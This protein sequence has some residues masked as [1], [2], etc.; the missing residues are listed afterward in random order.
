MTTELD[1]LVSIIASGV[2]SLELIYSKRGA[3]IPSLDDGY[4]PGPGAVDLGDDPAVV[5]TAHLVVAAA[6]QLIAA[7][8]APE[9]NIRELAPS[10]FVSSSLAFTVDTDVPDIL[11]EA[12]PQVGRLRYLRV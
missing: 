9:E 6:A 7:V 5:D 1:A 8:G 3:R 2:H 4:G 10:M 12:G 11:D